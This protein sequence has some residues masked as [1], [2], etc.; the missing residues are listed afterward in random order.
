MRFEAFTGGFYSFPSLNA[1][2]QMTMN[3][4]PDLVEGAL[5]KA[6]NPGGGEKARMVLTPTPGLSLYGTLPYSPCRG[7]WPGEERLFAVGGSH[8]YEVTGPTAFTDHGSIGTDATNSPVQI[9]PNGNQLFVVSAGQAYI[10]NGALLAGMKIDAGTQ[11]LTGPTG[12]IFR[13]ADVGRSVQITGGTGFSVQ[14]QVITSVNGTG[15]A[16][17][18]A[19][20][21][22]AGSTGGAGA[23]T[24]VAKCEFSSKL[25]DLVIDAVT[26]YLTGDTGPIFDASDIGKMLQITGGD[27]FAVQTQAIVSV[28]AGQAIGA[29]SWGTS[30]ST[31]GTGVE[32]LGTYVT[33]VQGAFLDGSFFAV[34]PSSKIVYYSDVNDGTSWDPL[35]FFTKEAYPDNVAAILADHE[36]LYLF[37]DLES[38]EVWAGVGSG[39][40]PFARNPSYFMHY[41][42]QAPWSVSRLENGLAW[43]GGT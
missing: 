20:W 2:S 11:G 3:Y 36:Q 1:A 34:K 24:G 32:W 29:V 25:Y 8:L 9:I 43:I 21:G 14:T 15:Q 7:L 38:T 16:F 18:A 42:C 12:G 4:Y 5:P 10:D 35:H 22:T 30:G 13:A 41:G 19:S 17:G 40:N 27:G 23:M 26:G 37:G 31:G 6:G 28:V 39:T 33:A